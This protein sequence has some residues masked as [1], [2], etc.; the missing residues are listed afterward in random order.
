MN[1]FALTAL[2]LLFLLPSTLHAQSAE[3]QTIAKARVDSVG[4]QI[5]QLLPGTDV[6][7]TSQELTATILDGSEKGQTVSFKN[8]FTQLKEGDLFYLRHIRSTLE[9]PGDLYSVADPYRLPALIGLGVLFLVIVCAFGGIQGVRGLA[10]L[11]GSLV[12][13][14]YLLLPG[15]VKGYPPVLVAIG[16]SSLVIILGSYVTHGFNRTTTAA[17]VGMVATVAIT[18]VLASYAVHAALL[19]G[20]TSEDSA[21]LHFQYH[22]ALNLVGILMSGIL[23]G[24][25]GVL[26]D[27]A[28]GQ[29][30]AVEELM[31]A[32]PHLTKREVYK[33]AIR[34]GRE[35]IGALVNT[36][37][38]AYV[39]A[40][41][42]LL[43]LFQGATSSLAFILNGEM[44]AS[45]I[46]RIL[47]GSIGIVL[48]VPITTLAALWLVRPSV[49]GTRGRMHAH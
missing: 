9:G 46:V 31:S 34:I 4:K 48:A 13:I 26:Y 43:L 41:L 24:L 19:S 12:L 33:R 21:Y 40:A 16:V 18:G 32:G 5:T 30:V 8:D 45:E 7:S 3:T 37:A 39:G 23:I 49:D 38:I 17:V 15:I 35:H 47:I 11:A 2:S 10:S 14:F 29:A 27:S 22:G 20:Y 1:R 6:P 25:L 44:F 36:L 28:I 42:P